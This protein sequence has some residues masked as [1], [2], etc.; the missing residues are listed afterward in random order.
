MEKQKTYEDLLSA[1]NALR[2]ELEETQYQLEEATDTIEA[3]R[4]G[5]VDALIVKSGD[6]HQ[7]YTLKSVDQTYRIFIEQMTEGAVTLNKAGTILYCNSKFAHLVKLPLE[8]IIGKP[9]LQFVQQSDLDAFYQLINNAWITEIKGEL[10]L[11]TFDSGKIPVLLSLK[12]LT[13]DEG[14]SMSIIVT[15]L[16]TLKE[17][18]QLL[19]L[20]NEQLEQARQFTL[21]LNVNLEQ[22][23]KERTGD[24]EQTI[25][26]K[27]QVE[28]NLRK[29][30][31]QLSQILETMAEGV[32]I[33]DLQGRIT[34]ANP[35]ALKIMGQ[36]NTDFS[37]RIYNDSKWQNFRV[38]GS[39]MPKEEHPMYSAMYTG[40]P[41]HDFEIAIHPPNNEIFY[42]SISAAP[43]RDEN[44]KVVACVGT[45]MDVTQRRKIIQQKDEFISVASHELKTPI[46]SLKASLQ[47]LSKMQD[48]PSEKMLPVLIQQAN[49]SLDRVNSLVDDLLNASRMSQGQLH[50]KKRSFVISEMIQEC[51]AHSGID[52]KYKAKINGDQTLQVFADP[53]RIDQ[54]VVNFISNAA[55][56]APGSKY[57]YVS[58]EEQNDRAKVSV[59]DHGPGIPIE[60]QQHLFD[61]YY[62]V[63]TSGIQYSGLGLGLYISSEIIKKHGGQIGVDSEVGKGSTFW[64]SLPLADNL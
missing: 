21:D 36:S 23:V 47:L 43:I 49:K 37:N 34:F 55:K 7:L 5:E 9:F 13:L 11:K 42:I 56:Y 10:G 38:D 63:D 40:K 39:P 27:S 14:P 28:V 18:Q 20:K 31:E 57:I 8:K 17:S 25:L 35:M 32:V 19:Q 61:R 51:V 62:R 58:I 48:K 3:I 26:Q 30:Q 12:M 53:D 29:S 16:T 60:K 2:S 44:G 6:G 33:M 64:F 22:I 59:T 41:V 52:G 1:F 45:F 54:V 4:L 50:L 46:T 24:L 15:D